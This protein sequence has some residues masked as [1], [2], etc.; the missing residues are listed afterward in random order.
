MVLRSPR[1]AGR[2]M[3]SHRLPACQA[4]VVRGAFGVQAPARPGYGLAL[5]EE[6][7][8]TISI[9]DVLFYVNIPALALGVGLYRLVVCRKYHWHQNKLLSRSP[10][11]HRGRRPQRRYITS[12]VFYTAAPP[13]SKTQLPDAPLS[14][15]NAKT[16][17]AR[18]RTSQVDGSRRHHGFP[19]GAV[20]PVIGRLVWH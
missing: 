15:I 17:S 10:R 8:R 9:G 1:R 11:P 19:S 18:W 12:D 6:Q 3:D 16:N 4:T 13:V 7:G 20:L 2:F 14:G 5:T